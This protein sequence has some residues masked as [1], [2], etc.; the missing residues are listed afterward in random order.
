MCFE[1]SDVGRE[2]AFDIIDACIENETCTAEHMELVIHYCQENEDWEN[3]EHYATIGFSLGFLPELKENQPNFAWLRGI[4][5]V[6][7]LL[8]FASIPP[9]L[10]A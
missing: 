4:H 2:A 8:L 3:F 10:F 1:W 5:S 7:T 9:A 6:S